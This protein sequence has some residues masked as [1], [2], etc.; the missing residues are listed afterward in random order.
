MGRQFGH[1]LQQGITLGIPGVITK[2]D[3]NRSGVQSAGTFVGQ[4][5][6]M[7]P[8]PDGNS[9]PGQTRRSFLAVHSRKEG[10]RPRLVLPGKDPHAH[11]FQS[12]GAPPGLVMLPVGDPLDPPAS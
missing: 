8:G 12:P 11:G 1:R 3:S 2:A 10:H 6:T 7:E 9:P 4:R 5:G